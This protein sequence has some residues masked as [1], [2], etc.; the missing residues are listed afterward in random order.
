MR[1]GPAV[2][3]VEALLGSFL[4]KASFSGAFCVVFFILLASV[5]SGRA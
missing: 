4:W 5:K 2:V 3:L 1:G